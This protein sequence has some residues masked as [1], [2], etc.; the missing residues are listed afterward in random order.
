MLSWSTV[1]LSNRSPREPSGTHTVPNIGCLLTVALVALIYTTQNIRTIFTVFFQYTKKNWISF[2]FDDGDPSNFLCAIFHKDFF[3]VD[4]LI[5]SLK[6]NT[7]YNYMDYV[8]GQQ[9]A[10]KNIYFTRT[11]HQK[12]FLNNSAIQ[13]CIRLLEC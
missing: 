13:V 8:C 3:Q 5:A 12:K 2:A 6:R 10:C 9:E 1:I 4:S 7:N 11:T